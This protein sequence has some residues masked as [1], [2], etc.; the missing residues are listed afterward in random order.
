MF[1]LSSMLFFPFI[2]DFSLVRMSGQWASLVKARRDAH[3]QIVINYTDTLLYIFQYNIYIYIYLL[4]IAINDSCFFF[5]FIFICIIYIYIFFF[6]VLCIY[7]YIYNLPPSLV[8][9]LPFAHS[10]ILLA[11]HSSSG[12]FSSFDR[13]ID[14][15][16]K[17]ESNLFH[18]TL[19]SWDF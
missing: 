15:S 2:V 18:D 11:T 3:L 14:R 4:G 10:F 19:L 1:T 6:L 17:F 13:R 8:P 7:I 16:S 9:T 12:S 5:S